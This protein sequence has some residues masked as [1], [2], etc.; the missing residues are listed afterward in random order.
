MTAAVSATDDM[1]VYTWGN[2]LA[3]THLADDFES[4]NG[5]E[6]VEPG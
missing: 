3:L 5:A 2:S 6:I 4:V 1:T